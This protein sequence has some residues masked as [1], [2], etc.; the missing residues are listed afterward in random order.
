MYLHENEIKRWFTIKLE[1][2]LFLKPRDASSNH[3][4]QDLWT[5]NGIENKVEDVSLS[6][7]WLTTF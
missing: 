4:P 1:M 5:G 3:P 7:K 6:L 2:C